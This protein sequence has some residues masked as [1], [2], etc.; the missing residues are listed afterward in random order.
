MT[1]PAAAPALMSRDGGEIDAI[2]L[3]ILWSQMIAIVDEMAAELARTAFSLLVRE[4]NDLA[5]V[6][7][8]ANGRAI[9]QSTRSIPSFSTVV[10]L[11]LKHMLDEFPAD[12]LEPGDILITNDPWF[13]AGHLPDLVMVV[14][15]HRDGRLIGYVGAV[16]H[17]QD[18]GGP[19]LS[20]GASDVYGEG[21]QIP[22]CK[23]V[24]AGVD[25]PDVV[26]MIRT[27]VRVPDLVLGD[28]SSQIAV[29]R[30]GAKRLLA[31]LDDWSL[32]DLMD[33]ANA[34]CARGA[35]AVRASIAALAPGTYVS[36]IESDGVGERVRV[37]ATVRVE[38]DRISVDY[39]GSS[40]QSSIGINSVLN[41]TYA[42]TVYALKCLLCPDIP[43]NQGLMD[44]FT[45]TAPE[46]SVVNPRRPAPVGGRA[47]TGHLLPDVVMA[48]LG[49]IVP[50]GVLAP[51]GAPPW[52]TVLR[53]THQGR[54]FT[55]SF[56]MGIGMGA[57][58]DGDGVHCVTFPS[59]ASSAPIEMLERSCP[60]RFV[61]K[62][63]R[64]DSGGL[65]RHR[66]G[67]GQEITLEVIGDGPMRLSCL[68]GRFKIPARGA[69]GGG[70]GL[71][72]AI[73]VNGVDIA[74]PTGVVELRAGDV[75]T[76]LLPGGGGYGAPTE[77]DSESARRD[78]DLGYTSVNPA[79]AGA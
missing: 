15:V 27:N 29:S 42:Y 25:N 12:E 61:A 59:N 79:G 39:T 11:A 63:L 66:G 57:R 65:G 77:R 16:A 10:P 9:A 76:L 32:D 19:Q 45:V 35:E 73:R 21:L 34:I 49:E 33:L 24:E 72:G 70:D 7:L 20:G 69:H 14:P 62:R 55:E 47:L 6:I 48:A 26:R 74:D 60:V 13:G 58:S 75:V 22:P 8:D 5:C 68:A 44:M 51:S 41:Y 37:V 31:L 54:D 53:G 23:L 43:N 1:N 18:T 3:E 2:T 40:P 52:L 30:L 4:G 71:A 50:G 17:L 78:V 36:E 28:I 56:V 67:L 38:R 46:G 64:T